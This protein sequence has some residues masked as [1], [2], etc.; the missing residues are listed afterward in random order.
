MATKLF[1]IVSQLLVVTGA[2]ALEW[3][4]KGRHQFAGLAALLTLNAIPF[5]W[6][7]LNF[8]FGVGLALWQSSRGP[9]LPKET[10]GFASPFMAPVWWPYSPRTFSR[11]AFMA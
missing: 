8:Q 4:V 7:L 5:A 1:L 9:L 3:S 2:I 6:G 10:G 11:S